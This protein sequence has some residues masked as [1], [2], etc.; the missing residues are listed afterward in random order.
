VTKKANLGASVRSRLLTR[1]KAQKTEFG[2]LLTRF[3]LERLLYRLSVSRHR[4]QFLLK[5]ALLFDLWFDEPHRPT[6]DVD[7]LAFGPPGLSAMAATFREICTVEADDG[8][9]FDSTS[10]K[11]QEIRKDA[12]YA[13]IRITL[14]GSLDGAR[15]PV[16][17]DIGFGDA[18]TPAPDE[19]QYPV[20]LIDLP[21]PRL[22]VYPRYTVIAEKFHAIV[23]LGIANSRMKDFFDLWVLTR[24][25]ELDAAILRRAVTATFARRGTVLP[26]N[27][28]VGLSNE[29]AAD[30]TKQTQWRAFTTRNQLTAPDLTTTRSL[31]FV[32][33]LNS[34]IGTT[35]RNMTQHWL[36]SV[37][38]RKKDRP[39][40][41]PFTIQ[42]AETLIA[43]IHRDWGEAQ[44]NYDEFRFFTGLRPSEQIALLVN[45]FD[46]IEGTLTINKARVAGVDKDSTKTREDRRI[47]LCP[48]ALQ[49][50][51]RQL[52]LRARR[53][54]ASKIEHGYLFFKESGEPICN[55]QYPYD[56]WRRTLSR[57][58]TIR[59]RKPYCA[60]HSSVSWNLMIDR[61]PLWVAKQ[62]GHSITSMLRV[63]AAWAEG[64]IE[65]DIK[66]IKRAMRSDPAGARSAEPL[67]QRSTATIAQR[68]TPPARSRPQS[69]PSHLAAD[70][71][72]RRIGESL[73]TGDAKDLTGGERG[74]RR[75]E[76]S[77]SISNLLIPRETLP[78]S[79]PR[80]PPSLSTGSSTGIPL[81]KGLNPG[82]GS[83]PLYS[84]S[85]RARSDTRVASNPPFR[86]LSYTK[87]V[88]ALV[89]V[90]GA[91]GPHPVA[92]PGVSGG[93]KT[94]E[95]G[96]FE[97]R[98]FGVDGAEV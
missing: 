13:G 23:T 52:A 60:R 12:N 75:I 61:N 68:R 2:L 36:K 6:R 92:C 48:R 46:P 30:L 86:P 85:S 35:R 54:K 78:P 74:I 95:I 25:S 98:V 77:W 38:I 70:L 90:P 55:L 19:A 97:N 44:G 58:N 18:V 89:T 7:F 63:Y 65:A 31:F 91:R 10:V 33:P 66:A 88:A 96:R 4:E 20:L 28:P 47:K 49:V 14:M 71:A 8:M 93:V 27:T 16:Q 81:F 50:L 32:E 37:R 24:H 1:A 3:A 29:F 15:C 83:L 51:R 9:V 57:L 39:V 43:A 76:T 45:D 73:S 21:A 67:K 22:R 26:T 40:I 11:A 34:A 42:E 82:N 59:Y 56:R 53:E 72:V 5:G 84:D 64:A 79:S 80:K 94:V 69:S 62:H 17:A 87:N 41:D